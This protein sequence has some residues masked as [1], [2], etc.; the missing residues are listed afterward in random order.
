MTKK[1]VP[2]VHSLLNRYLARFDMA[3]NYSVEEIEHWFVHT[4]GEQVVWT[5]VV[6]DEQSHKITDFWSFYSLESSIINNK[7]YDTIKAAYMFYYASEA[8]FSET[9]SPMETK[10]ALKTRLNVLIHDA[11]IIAKSVSVSPS[12]V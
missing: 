12:S 1:D 7:K 2:A 5:Y 9:L 8:A 11:L 10:A 3:P 4:D 6:E